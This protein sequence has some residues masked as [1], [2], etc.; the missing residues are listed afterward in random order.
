M[1][2][3]MCFS[4]TENTTEIIGDPMEGTSVWLWNNT[5]LVGFS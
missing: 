3:A 2:C 5:D 4:L 1:N